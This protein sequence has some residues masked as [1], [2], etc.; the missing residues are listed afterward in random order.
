MIQKVGL[1]D[2]FLTVE[3]EGKASR[4]EVEVE[5][6]RLDGPTFSGVERHIV[7][8]RKK[9]QQA[10]PLLASIWI[11]DDGLITFYSNVRALCN[12]RAESKTIKILFT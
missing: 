6:Y 12:I 3:C 11:G 10:G 9:G 1:H 5:S 7:T 8:A 4:L 2:W